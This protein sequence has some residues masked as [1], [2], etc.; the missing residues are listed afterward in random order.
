MAK[1]QKTEQSIVDTAI[2]R[3]SVAIEADSHNREAAIEDLNFINGDQWDAKELKRR[4]AKGRP[5][6]QVNLLPKFVDQVVGDMLHTTPAIKVMVGDSKADPNIASI[7]QGLINDIEYRSNSKAIYGYASKQMVAC[8]YGAWRV[9][10]RYCDDNPFQQ[11][12]YL[13]SIRNPFLVYMDPAAK[14][15]NYADARW[16]FLLEKIPTEEFKERYPNAKTSGSI[17][18]STG[19]GQE[20]WYDG[21]TITVAEYF[22]RTAEPEVMVQLEDGRV[23]EE[24][25]YFELYEEWQ[26]ANDNLIAATVAGTPNQPPAQPEPKIAKRRV[27]NKVVIR[28]WV[29]TSQEII[30]GGV[31]GNKVPGKYI[32]LVLLKGKE[33]NI[34]GKN[35]VYSLVRHAKDSQKMV[36]YW[37]T[38]AA[39]AIALAPKTPWLAT[40][41]QI[42]GFENDYAAANVENF[43]VLQYNPDPEAQGPPQRVPTPNPPTAIFEQIRRGED[44]IKSIIGM[45][46]AD[47]GAPGSEQ[48]GAAIIARQKPSDIGTFEFSENLARA[49]LYTGKIINEMI[50]DVYDAERD[51]RIRKDDDSEVFVP[52]NTKVG[53]LIDSVKQGQKPTGLDIEKLAQQATQYGEDADFNDITC[54]KYDVV[55]S[56][57]P[58]YATQRQE[59][60]AHLLQLV[61]AM[62]QQMA[63][64]IDLIVEN[65]DFQAADELAKRLRAPLVAQGI[66]PPREGEQPPQ[67]QGPSP[68]VQVQ[69]A[70]VEVEKAKVG[71]AEVKAQNEAIKAEVEKMRMQR[72]MLEFQ[73]KME[74]AKTDDARKEAKAQRDYQIDEAKLR[75]QMLKMMKEI[76]GGKGDQ[77]AP[78]T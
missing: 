50:P 48:T 40:P 69:M 57:G 9:L 72:D 13:E 23:I 1:K 77:R 54:G 28:Q 15:Q 34:E 20:H 44:N 12:I 41:K 59:S 36:N 55:V 7:R 38:A 24:E 46:N 58:S 78:N 68:E 32:N 51:V 11:E 75:A 45:F 18:K 37:N 14:D 31:E 26:K 6:L 64:A 70:L 49:I 33:L 29:L 17:S 74:L 71:L 8:G 25:D 52:V 19:M 65:M 43:P 21:D 39:E 5:A 10:T 42:E 67:P 66:I 56:V 62:P 60:Q 76:Q 2:K 35:H 53:T 4:R 47:L 63:T 73:M 27:T 3:L 30:S 16:G 22:E 61:Q